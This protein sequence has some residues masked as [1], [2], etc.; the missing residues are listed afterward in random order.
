M[1]GVVLSIQL[2]SQELIPKFKKITEVLLSTYLKKTVDYNN[3]FYRL[4]CII[5][6][7]EIKFDFSTGNA[8]SVAVANNKNDR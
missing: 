1:K 4:L 5:I 2:F 6:F 3:V 8:I 7:E